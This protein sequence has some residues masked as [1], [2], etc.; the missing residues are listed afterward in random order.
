MIWM[1]FK[2]GTRKRGGDTKRIFKR[3][4]RVFEETPFFYNEKERNEQS[5]SL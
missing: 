1:N 5:K 3:D 4:K 2:R